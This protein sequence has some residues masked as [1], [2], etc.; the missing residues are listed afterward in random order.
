M[1]ENNS[2]E[3]P[4]ISLPSDCEEKLALCEAQ[5]KEYLEGWQRAKADYINFKNE[6][7]R[8]MEDM[9]K[10]VTS[11]FVQD[12]LPVLDSFDLALGH[13]M[14]PEVEK[15]ILLIRSQFEDALKKRGLETIKISSGEI[16]NL[17]RHEGIGEVESDLPEGVIAEEVQR[18]YMLRGKVLRPSRV[19][20]AKRKDQ[21]Q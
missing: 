7:G 1:E 19:R 6:E 12:I 8:R 2:E 16:F 20:L 14:A 4:P 11:G 18:G 21:N 13:G 5:K 10:F 3:K 15:G 17:E 9:A